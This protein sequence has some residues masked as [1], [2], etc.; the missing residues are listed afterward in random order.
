MYW[1]YH[2]DFSST[3]QRDPGHWQVGLRDPDYT[4]SDANESYSWVARY[5]LNFLNAYFKHD[6]SSR[7]FL[8]N[9]PVENG[10]PAH[11]FN[12]DFRAASGIAPTLT[13]FTA[14]VG[15]R[16]FDH[17]D[18]VYTAFKAANP[19]FKFDQ[20]QMVDWGAGLMWFQHYPEAIAIFKL[21]TVLFPNQA[22]I[23]DQLAGAYDKNGQRDLAVASYEKSLTIRPDDPYAKAEL[24][25]LR[26]PAPAKP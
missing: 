21:D 11:L 12:V 9:T 15:K 4:Q 22:P 5:V 19:D 6:E 17:V 14:E 16:G 3:F 23:Y 8:K 20:R 18:D 26:A 25:K 13:A 24:E 2:G 10:A 7:K 1:M